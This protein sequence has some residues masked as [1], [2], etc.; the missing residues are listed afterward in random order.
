MPPVG[1]KVESDENIGA[2]VRYMLTFF[3]LL[4]LA[5]FTGLLIIPVIRYISC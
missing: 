1:R 3:F 4:P 5:R 2:C